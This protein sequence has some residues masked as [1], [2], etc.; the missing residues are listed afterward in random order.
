MRQNKVTWWFMIIGASLGGYVPGL[1]GANYFS[2][3][4]ILFSALGSILGIWL[5]FKI[6]R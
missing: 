6:T 4:S 3:S 2:F 5:A 1:W